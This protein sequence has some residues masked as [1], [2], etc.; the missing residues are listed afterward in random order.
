MLWVVYK[1]RG[2]A[3]DHG[4]EYHRSVNRSACRCRS[5]KP[6]AYTAYDEGGSRIVNEDKKTFKLLFGD[7]SVVIKSDGGRCTYGISAY[8]SEGYGTYG[9]FAH[10]KQ[11]SQGHA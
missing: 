6:Q 7:I 5:E 4:G 9:G 11:K 1:S 8:K 10:S 2:D 3:A